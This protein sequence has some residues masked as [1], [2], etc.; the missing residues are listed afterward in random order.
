MKPTFLIGA[1]K[2]R[3]LP[4]L[5]NYLSTLG[6]TAN[7][8]GRKLVYELET[9]KYKLVIAHL[10]WEDIRKKY[11]QF[12][13]I[14]YGADQWLEE[15]HKAMIGLQYFP[16]GNCRISLL[17]P[18]AKANKSAT[19]ILS[20][21]R[22]ATSYPRLAQEYL[23]VPVERIVEM[24]G[25]VET[26]IGLHWAD[27]VFDVIESGTTARENGL[28]E[29]KPYIKFG[30]VLATCRPEKIPLMVRCGLIT[31]PQN[32][33]SV[34]FEGNDGTGKSTIAKHLVQNG[35]WSDKPSVLVSPYSGDVGRSAEALRKDSSYFDWASVVGRNHWRAPRSITSV[36]DRSILTCLTELLENKCSDSEIRLIIDTWKPL[37]DLVFL[38]D[39]SPEESLQRIRDRG[40]EDEF[41]NFDQLVKYRGLYEAAATYLQTEFSIPVVK[42]NTSLSLEESL[43]D[44]KNTL[45]SRGLI[46]LQ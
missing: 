8:R 37:P 46:T 38:C 33:V 42:L 26:A 18:E 3:L 21:S 12:D 45:M 27:C 40:G 24:S 25:S 43:R 35:L 22:V 14:T 28:V 17:V 30:A 19:D 16:Q 11:N 2:G 1:G 5:D 15:S 6:L 29:L 39:V 23:G 41:G 10:R 20:T 7:N 9:D 31:N 44:V 36:Y 34:A 32:A 4:V 13:L